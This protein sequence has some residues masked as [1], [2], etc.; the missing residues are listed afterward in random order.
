M[1]N[2]PYFQ[3]VLNEI[4]PGLR[5]SEHFSFGFVLRGSV[6]IRFSNHVR[7]YLEHDILFFMPFETWSI[8]RSSPEAQI[9]LLHLDGFFLKEHCPDLDY[10]SLQRHHLTADLANENYCLLCEKLATI[11][12]H[13]V[14]QEL[15]SHLK[16]LSAVTE[17]FTALIEAYGSVNTESSGR[18]Y[19]IERSIRV[20][21]YL[22]E[23]Y[24][25]HFTVPEI[26]DEIG[27]HPQYF[28][29]WFRAQFGTSF[30]DYL[31]TFRVNHTIPD[32]LRTEKGILDI[33]LDHGFSNHKMYAAA[34][35]KV[36]GCSPR[37][38]R[39]RET[40]EYDNAVLRAG[41]GASP[42]DQVVGAFAWFRQFLHTDHTGQHPTLVQTGKTIELDPEALKKNVFL[43]ERASC[44]SA[45]RAYAC[46]R[47]NLQE[48]ILA[49]KKD[50]NLAALRVRDIFSDSL[51]IYF[52]DEEKHP[53]YNWQTL[54]SVFDFLLE[55]HITPFPEISYM[56]ERLAAKKQYAGY[57]YRP[58]VSRPKSM[59]LWRELIRH[60]L[61]H[62]LERYGKEELHTWDFDFWISPDLDL[63]QPY[64]YGTMEEFFDFYRETWETFHE[65]DPELRLGSANFSSISGYPWY[66][67]FFSY[68]KKHRITPAFLSMH[69]YGSE[70][71][72]PADSPGS[73]ES[74][75]YRRFSI[76]DPTYL[77][78]QIKKLREIASRHGF[79]TLPL[80]ISDWSLSFLPRDLVRETC[81]IGPWICYN[82]VK[83]LGLVD[84]LSFWALSDIHEEAF[85][86]SALF[87]GGPGALD[88][89]GLK[90]AS[91]NTLALLSRLGNRVYETGDYYLFA[92]RE[93]VYQILLFNLIEFDDM[94]TTIDNTVID[95]THRYNIYRNA[96]SLVVNILLHLPKGSYL[97][98]K[99]EVN[100]SAGSAYDVWAQIGFPET[101]HHDVEE[102][103]EKSSVPRLT[104]EVQEVE[105]TL[106]L[107]ETIP[108]H[109]VLL[110][111]IEKA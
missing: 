13:D 60:F 65:V 67:A 81:Y 57:Q 37:E 101:L 84:K 103:I 93:E 40:A 98:K 50:M 11:L 33:A 78:M 1:E 12:F 34:F 72:R 71:R 36:Y 47:S 15:T 25:E 19:N 49:A 97:I 99:W 83:T 18:N 61:M 6:Q 38:Y 43:S 109:G 62:Y 76:S 14:K 89:H 3:E 42:G 26:A 75:D 58:N 35:R 111:E 51:Y 2:K 4:T 105:E 102:Y 70:E 46:L 87:Y 95:R 56:P 104:C 32:L 82:Y 10:V 16:S 29:T 5:W 79:S 17:L 28:S 31:T 80:T 22:T 88:Y 8:V 64:W 63:K 85:P 100:R 94:F 27:L 9:L 107:D 92:K 41:E 108:S 39:K 59:K 45:G 68:C 23:H 7:E 66:E 44:L 48:Q 30:I 20:L 21:T 54:D 24:T 53:I 96:N 55:H 74:I 77:T 86:E 110:L 73:L 91:Y 69:L 106:L 52:E 90:K